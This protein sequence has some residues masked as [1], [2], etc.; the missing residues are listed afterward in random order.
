MFE[1]GQVVSWDGEMGVVAGVI[2]EDTEWIIEE[3]GEDEEYDIEA[4]EDNPVYV[5]ALES[6]DTV[7][8]SEDDD[9]QEDEWDDNEFED[10]DSVED[11]IM[12]AELS[13][14]YHSLDNPADYDEITAELASPALD[15]PG[16]NTAG[17]G[18]SKDPPGWDR[19]SYLKAWSTFK[20]KWRICFPRMTRHFGP[21]MA[22]RWCSA[23][24]D[25]VYQTTRWRVRGW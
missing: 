14:V 3:D 20:G 12:D 6:G 15:L 23:L 21:R 8:L 19:S 11:D 17:I 16:A 2:T 10:P 13:P 5:V 4:S 9:L 1:V 7:P 24:K 18:F 22:K 25:E